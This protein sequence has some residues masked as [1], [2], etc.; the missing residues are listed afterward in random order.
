VVN[1]VQFVDSISA[2]PTVRL[3]LNALAAQG[4]IVGADGIDLSPP[5]LRRAVVSSF[6]ADG[7]IIPASAYDNRVIKLPIVLSPSV[8][9]VDQAA[10]ALQLLARELDRPTNILRVQLNGATSP[11]FFRTFSAPDYDWSMPRLLAVYG[12]AELEIPAEP[13][14]YGLKQTLSPVTVNNDPAAGSNGCFWD[15]TGVMGDVETPAVISYVGNQAV[16]GAVTGQPSGYEKSRQALFAV[17][18]RGTPAN[19]PFVLQ[20]ET[21]TVGTDTTVQTTD[22]AMSGATNN[23]TRTTFAFTGL[24]TRLNKA[25]FLGSASTDLRGIYR[26]LVRYRKSV[27]A[28]TITMSLRWGFSGGTGI[29][30]DTVTLPTDAN[31]T[32]IRYADL[33]LISLPLAPDPQYDGFSGV[34]LLVSGASFFLAV[35]AGRPA[36]SGNLDI[37]HFLLIPADDHLAFVGWPINFVVPDTAV[38]DGAVQTV[39]GLTAGAVTAMAQSSMVGSFPMISPGVTNRIFFVRDAAYTASATDA[40]TNNT[41]ITLSYWPRYLWVRPA[42]T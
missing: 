20:A 4:L 18:R 28:D 33:G 8:T 6:L 36:G 32:N 29:V 24:T 7:S 30:N 40:I 2:T 42:T 16:V 39:Y 5:P 21:M 26:V 17:R 11:V 12:K 13:F 19:F 10:T 35:S 3:D 1:V 9:T 27:A 23:Y 31:A 22:A 15:V 25:N 37:D 38:V 34:E 41:S 14:G